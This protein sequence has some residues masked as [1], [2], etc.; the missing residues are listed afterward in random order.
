MFTEHRKEIEMEKALRKK[1]IHEHK[2]EFNP[3]PKFVYIAHAFGGDFKNIE[4]T[5]QYIYKILQNG[6][7]IIPISPLHSF[8]FLYG[9][10]D[11]IKA[12]KD[13]LSLLVMCDRMIVC[14]EY[15]ESSFV[16]DEIKFAYENGIEV[17]YME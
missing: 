9:N 3:D 8:G 15:P 4:K 16:N 1:I 12:K 10:I 7:D 5:S 14:G 2:Q 11:E 6:E 17:E 13:C